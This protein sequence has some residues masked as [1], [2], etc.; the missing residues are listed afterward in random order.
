MA[1]WRPFCLG[2]SVLIM[3]ATP[4]S[5]SPVYTVINVTVIVT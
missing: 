1:K 3:F 5:F 2:L 4:V